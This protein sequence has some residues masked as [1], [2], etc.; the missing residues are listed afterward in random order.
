MNNPL[1]SGSRLLSA[2]YGVEN[3]IG[4]RGNDKDNDRTWTRNMSINVI[5]DNNINASKELDKKQSTSI[6]GYR[7]LLSNNIVT[8]TSSS[9]SGSGI[10]G[11]RTRDILSLFI[12]SIKTAQASSRALRT[13]LFNQVAHPILFLYIL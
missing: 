7:N 6:S 1:Q 8:T 9:S 11:D 5:K 12:G 2:P 4:Y 13:A 3:K 10:N